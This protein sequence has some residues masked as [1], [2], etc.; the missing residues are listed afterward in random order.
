[1][2]VAPFISATISPP[3]SGTSL[4]RGGSQHYWA[5]VYN[6][7]GVRIFISSGYAPSTWKF[8]NVKASMLGDH[9]TL[10]AVNGSHIWIT[11]TVAAHGGR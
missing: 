11:T 5:G 6:P 2:T 1:M 7:R 10:Y 9:H 3:A 4:A 8:W